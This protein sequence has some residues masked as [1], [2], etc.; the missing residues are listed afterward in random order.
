MN[1]VQIFNY[2]HFTNHSFLNNQTQWNTNMN[3]SEELRKITRN[4]MW[5]DTTA[6]LRYRTRYGTSSISVEEEI[7]R[8]ENLSA[9]GMF[10]LSESQIILD[11]E[12]EI[13]IRFNDKICLNAMGKILRK[14][15]N[16]VAIKFTEIDKDKLCDCIMDRMNAD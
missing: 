8:I 13:Q 16:G 10:V 12:V 15:E 2:L 14:E 1:Y 9:R 3:H 5:P 4:V 11:T 7:V 6:H